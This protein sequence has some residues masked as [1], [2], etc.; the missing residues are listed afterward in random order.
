[1]I[2]VVSSDSIQSEQCQWELS[3]AREYQKRIIPAI[4]RK[5]Y[6]PL[7]FQ[8]IGLS[9][10][11]YVSFA[12]DS[13]LFDEVVGQLLEALAIDLEDV[14]VY[15]R[16]LTK[17]HDW[18][19]NSRPDWG[20][21]PQQA[22]VEIQHWHQNRQVDNSANQREIQSLLPLQEEYI[23]AS[24][25]HHLILEQQRTLETLKNRRKRQSLYVSAL[26]FTLC[27]LMGLLLVTRLG[28]IK[29]LVTSLEERKGIDALIIALKAAKR[30]KDNDFFVQHLR[31]NLRA[32]ATTAL[33]RATLKL[34][35]INRLEG[36][37]GNVFHVVFSPDGQQLVSVGA[38]KSV[39][40][41]N[42][43]SALLDEA[44][45]S[46][47]DGVETVAYSSDGQKVATGSRD[48]VVKLWDSTGQLEKT[49]PKVHRQS[50]YQVAFSRGSQYLASASE[51]G[52]VFLWSR[53]DGFRT[54]VVLR[55]GADRP[56]LRIA[57]SSDG[58]YI[59]SADVS[60]QVRVWSLQGELLERFEHDAPVFT[61]QFS[62]ERNLLAFAG[63]SGV[64]QVQ[65]LETDMAYRLSD[66]DDV[67]WQIRF[68]ADGATLASA[69]EDSTV[70]LWTLK[71]QQ[72]PTLTHTLRGHRKGVYRVRF[73]PE[74]NLLTTGG[75][76]GT[77][78]LWLRD[79]GALVDTLEGHK[80]EIS[81]LAFSPTRPILASSSTD[82]SI[83]F[84]N[85]DNPIQALP[86]NNWVFDVAFRADG[87]M[88]ASSGA[89]TLRL[90][91]RDGS[92]RAHILY[93]RG[94]NVWALDY[95]PSGELLA[96]GGD[97]GHIQIWKPE[98]S[99]RKAIQRLEN[100]HPTL[101]ASSSDQG[102]ADLRF[103][104][105]RR[106]LASGGA[107][108]TLKL[109]RIAGDQLYRYVTLEHLTSVTGVDFSA[110]SQFIVTSTSAQLFQNRTPS[111]GGSI[112]L[113]QFP[114]GNQQNFFP[115]R[116]FEVGKTDHTSDILTVAISPAD[117][118]IIA[119]GGAD[120]KIILW[121]M[122]GKALKTLWGHTAEV[123]QVSFSKDGLFLASSSKDGTIRLWTLDGELISVLD[124]HSRAVSSVVFGPEGGE[125]LA[126][127]SFDNDVLLWQLWQ[128]PNLDAS[129]RNKRQIILEMLIGMGCSS[130]KPFLDSHQTQDQTNQA[131][132]PDELIFL[133]DIKESKQFC[134]NYFDQN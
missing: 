2:F 88:V 134:S 76:D 109:W 121:D 118:P 43:G 34:R 68:S 130:A 85:I 117:T 122:T 125:T 18:V 71:L 41:W 49:L 24:Q 105:N 30:V 5:D 114:R 57:F 107:D 72:A 20:L 96:A 38:D 91:R 92:L 94:T 99:T 1:F 4:Y 101:E 19:E 120:G 33:H 108:K 132:N 46:H 90:W 116:V 47:T 100:A 28:E 82:G 66:H 83:R 102:V 113:W 73:S 22:L 133:E 74:D 53:D 58:Q 103:S 60:G 48:G 112:N 13:S 25:Q 37:I 51:D 79:E 54:P 95:H 32:N 15:N 16:L 123:T 111:R 80:A 93:A 64:I 63:V 67:I 62:P 119:S 21:M 115:I 36:H 55:H 52:D 104:P 12:R 9:A 11:N 45:F 31:P 129:K 27:S 29:A 78:H 7:V 127:A 39:R 35:E 6:D 10:I 128:L 59:A 14:K 87:A 110:D 84:W 42:V 70:K 69:S 44:M 98:V 56:V 97:D 8:R 77:I 17:A 75:A 61:M 65:D 86:H 124:R 50:I 81:S 89:N 26:T 106:W 3:K 23:Y 40:F 126:S 131:L